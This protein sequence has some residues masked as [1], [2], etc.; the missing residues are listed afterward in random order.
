MIKKITLLLVFS[1]LYLTLYAQTWEAKTSMPPDAK[2]RTHAATFALDG[3]GYVTLGFGNDVEDYADFHSYDPNTDAWTKLEDFPGPL[4]GYVVALNTTDL[5]WVGFGSGPVAD[6]IFYYSDLWTYSPLTNTWT[7]KATCDCP[8]RNHPAFVE[9][10][11]KIYVG[12][13]SNNIEGNLNDFWVYDIALDSWK[14][15]AP[16]PSHGRH[17]PFYF[18]IGKYPYVGLGHGSQLVN[19]VRIY[20]DFYKYDP[21]T[22]IWERLNDFPGEGRV[23][24]TQFSHNGKGYVL[25]GQGDDHNNLAEG[26]FWEYDSDT[27]T[28]TQLASVPGGGRWAPAAFVIG[29]TAY[30]T[31]GLS[32]D[33]FEND[34][35]AYGFESTS[36]VFDSATPMEEILVS[37][38]PTS[39]TI[40]IPADFNM[41]E[42]TTVEIVA[43][44]G[45]PFSVVLNN[46]HAIDVSKL[47]VGLYYLKIRTAQKTAVAK[48]VKLG[49]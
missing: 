2:G 21:D 13:G 1:G 12:A 42:N 44:N 28:W 31:G 48:F 11:G 37:P 30:Y 46:Q 38:N 33:Q 32:D 24:G 10:E 34:L 22:D 29:D 17:H 5:G 8:G 40:Q 41:D 20:K 43:A 18:S 45:Q 7:E 9:A 25:S 23:A 14:E 15:I 27:D 4:R 35:W 16:L 3:L 6:S 49:Q 36:S 39:S 47:P 26:E 19:G